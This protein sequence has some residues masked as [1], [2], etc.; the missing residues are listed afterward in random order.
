MDLSGNQLLGLIPSAIGSLKSLWSLNLSRNGPTGK[1]PSS[2]RSLISLYYLNY[3]TRLFE[4]VS[5]ESRSLWSSQRRHL[6]LLSSRN[7]Q[8]K[9]YQILIFR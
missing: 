7:V 4:P 2:F 1:S 5:P 8:Q 3:S 6:H 9:C